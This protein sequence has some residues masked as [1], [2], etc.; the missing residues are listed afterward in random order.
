MPAETIVAIVAALGIG[1]AAGMLAMVRRTP[2]PPRRCVM[3][4]VMLPAQ[5]PPGTGCKAPT[6]RLRVEAQGAARSPA[7]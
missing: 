5:C 1:F 7:P 3:C 2:P 4:R 6:A